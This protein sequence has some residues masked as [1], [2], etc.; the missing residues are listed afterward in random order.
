[1]YKEIADFGD[2]QVVETHTGI[3][4]IGFNKTYHIPDEGKIE[5]IKRIDKKRKRKKSEEQTAFTVVM[6]SMIFMI[7]MIVYWICFGY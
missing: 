3:D 1:M 4:L 7:W 5:E 6:F 2:F